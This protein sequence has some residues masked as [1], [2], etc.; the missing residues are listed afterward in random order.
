MISPT[1]PTDA[2]YASTAPVQS[3]S[4]QASQPLPTSPITIAKQQ[5]VKKQRQ[6][7]SQIQT[8]Q[9]QHPSYIH[10]LAELQKK[11][12]SLNLELH[13]ISKQYQ[14]EKNRR[15]LLEDELLKIRNENK[16]LENENLQYVTD[17]EDL[18]EDHTTLM[19]RDSAYSTAITFVQNEFSNIKKHLTKV[20][21]E[22]TR[23]QL[24]LNNSHNKDGGGG[25]LFPRKCVTTTI[26]NNDQTKIEACIMM[27]DRLDFAIVIIEHTTSSL[28]ELLSDQALPDPTLPVLEYTNYPN[29]PNQHQESESHMEQEE[30]DSD[31]DGD[32]NEKVGDKDGDYLYDETIDGN[33]DDNDNDSSSDDD[34]DQKS[35]R[36]SLL[37]TA[38]QRVRES[39]F[40][41]S[42]TTR[43]SVTSSSST[44][45]S[46]RP[47]SMMMNRSSYNNPKHIKIKKENEDQLL[48]SI[49]YDDNNNDEMKQQQKDEDDNM[50]QLVRELF[51][52]H[53]LKF[54][55]FVATNHKHV[56]QLAYDNGS[57][58]NNNDDDSP[59]EDHH[60]P[61]SFKEF[62]KSK[63]NER[64]EL[65]QLRHQ[66]LL[67][68]LPVEE[69]D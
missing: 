46:T 61:I 10:E 42:S 63:D 66:Q 14:L 21:D 5:L 68:Q 4:A 35:K 39:I 60:Y 32:I 45:T 28:E 44:T 2:P 58:N 62:V 7:K 64:K 13:H 25:G 17:I 69:E 37:K 22:T 47:S 36:P 34:E 16:Q 20:L 56:K 11:V 59:V 65:L 31:N 8:K 3:S 51:F 52:S 55:E 9:K 19:D 67:N 26:D 27:E 49:P 57:N 33:G 40:E 54:A 15:I 6:Q 41:F 43:S 38:F 23:L 50:E 24:V 29:H 30:Q 1:A 18:E 48:K 53:Q 12:C